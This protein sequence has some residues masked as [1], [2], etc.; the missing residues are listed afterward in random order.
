[1]YTGFKF[2]SATICFKLPKLVMQHVPTLGQAI[3]CYSMS[4]LIIHVFECDDL[5]V[6]R[7]IFK[8]NEP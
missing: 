7:Q 3:F 8:V 4:I 2:H 5:T 1:M 6:I